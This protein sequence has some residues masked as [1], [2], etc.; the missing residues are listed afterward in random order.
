M[1]RTSAQSEREVWPYSAAYAS[2][3]STS[4]GSGTSTGIGASRAYGGCARGARECCTSGRGDCGAVDLGRAGVRPSLCFPSQPTRCVC[5]RLAFGRR[6]SSGPGCIPD[7]PRQRRVWRHCGRG[8]SATHSVCD[9]PV[10][11]CGC[12]LFRVHGHRSYASR[13]RIRQHRRCLQGRR[14]VDRRRCNESV[15][16]AAAGP[17]VAAILKPSDD[18]WIA[19]PKAFG[20]LFMVFYGG[21]SN[22]VLGGGWSGV[23]SGAS[24]L[25]IGRAA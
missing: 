1:R 16:V 6:Y 12:A 23:S 24:A 10:C 11:C 18:R 3:T 8:L 5:E 2:G 7:H 13:P 20:V 9:C 4:T 14:K 17:S 25:P 19:G 15:G 21:C 22:L